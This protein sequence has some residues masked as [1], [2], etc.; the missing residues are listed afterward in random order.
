MT[1]HFNLYGGYT[2]DKK[3][4]L[5]PVRKLTKRHL[6][7][8]KI[9][10]QNVQRALDIFSRP[11]AA[12]LESYRRMKVS[13]FLGSEETISFLLIFVKWFEIHD[14]CNTYQG[15]RQRLPN[16]SPF[17]SAS[18]P[19]LQWLQDFIAWVESWKENAGEKNNFPSD[20]T[21]EAIV[22]T[23]KS[24]IAKIEYFLAEGGFQFVLSRK[25]NRGY[26]SSALVK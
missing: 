7:P 22:L 19:R 9:E 20:E 5:Q 10:R 8:A 26:T 21:H 2:R 4:L 17:T 14:V 6:E 1:Y 25:F 16:K 11:L 24:A 23:T 15:A 12:R 3:K 18:D 13:G